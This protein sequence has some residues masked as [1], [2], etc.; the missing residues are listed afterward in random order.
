M[1]IYVSNN[2]SCKRQYTPPPTYAGVHRVVCRTARIGR[3]VL[4]GADR[5]EPSRFPQ[6]RPL[7]G[8]D[9]NRKNRA[10]RGRQLTQSFP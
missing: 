9:N 6:H 5:G 2:L 4:R 10:C 7:K 3:R 1:S 8:Q